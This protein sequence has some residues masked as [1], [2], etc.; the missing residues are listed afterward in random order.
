MNQILAQDEVDSPEKI[1]KT[2]MN[3]LTIVPHLE[4]AGVFEALSEKTIAITVS[5]ALK[6]GQSKFGD[7]HD[8]IVHFILVGKEFY[9]R[10]DDDPIQKHIIEGYTSAGIESALLT[11]YAMCRREII[12]HHAFEKLYTAENLSRRLS[13]NDDL[14]TFFDNL[15]ANRYIIDEPRIFTF[16]ATKMSREEKSLVNNMDMDFFKK[17]WETHV[18]V[19]PLLGAYSDNEKL[20]K[21]GTGLQIL[22]F[23]T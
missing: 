14:D 8:Y 9:D 16:H 15:L 19:H 20:T 23:H 2:V 7:I 4:V 22:D 6:L 1:I 21:E 13:V 11:I 12:S 10:R 3:R 18:G 5:D 17:F